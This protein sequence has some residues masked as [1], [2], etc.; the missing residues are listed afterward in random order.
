MKKPTEKKKISPNHISAK[1]LVSRIYK[2][3]LQF[4][5]KKD[6]PDKN[7][8]AFSQRRHAHEKIV[9]VIKEQQVE[10]TTRCHFQSTRKAIVLTATTDGKRQVLEGMWRSENPHPSL[11]RL[12]WG[13]SG[14]QSHHSSP[15]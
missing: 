10:T 7:D 8:K 3:L 12:K 14:K 4:N 13:G 6:N 1:C 11:T 2:E 5:N 9:Y 15:H